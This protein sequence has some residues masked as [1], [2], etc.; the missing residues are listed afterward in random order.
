MK[1]HIY[2]RGK[3]YT[4]IIDLGKNPL[5]GKR[6]QKTKG[7]FK[8]KKEAQAALAAIQTEHHQGTY[9]NESEILTPDFI[10]RWLELYK[11]SRNV[12]ISSVR[13]R[14][15][16]SN[17]LK[18]YFNEIKLKEIT[19]SMY[20][21]F[22]FYLNDNYSENSLK[23][24]H[25]T[26]KM[27]FK[28]AIELKA[29]KTDP[30]QYAV[31]PK[32]QKTIEEI[33]EG[34]LP[35]Y[36]EKNELLKFLNAAKEA[37]LQTYV[38]FLV[39]AY[40]GIRVGELQALKWKDIDFKNNTINIYKTYYNF[41][42]NV[43]DYTLL[44]PKTAASKREIIV[45][46]TVMK[47][48]KKHKAQQSE[49]RLKIPSWHDDF[50]FTLSL[51][52]PGYPILRRNIALRMDDAI[53][54]AGIKRITPHGLRHTHTSLLAEAGASL[55]EIMERLGHINDKTTR[56]VYLHVTKEMKKEASQKFSELMKDFIC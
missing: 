22:L 50:V 31:V 40:T 36:F 46:K 33:E 13:V 52:H 4:Y 5:T 34:E 54:K 17:R 20:Q 41:N 23:G 44:T 2:K 16:E 28:K 49:L 19:Q 26:A 15:I 45:D 21:D 56:A 38:I 55:E 6:N 35:K 29:I 51:D 32:K 39:L 27:I 37:D 1:G 42:N 3:T 11:K 24:T 14:M 7:G 43:I 10:D 9:I 12:K 8:T 48:L 53:K 30:T 25:G 47:E 18:N